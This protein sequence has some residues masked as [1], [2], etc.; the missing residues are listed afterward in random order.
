MKD[1]E[2]E[3]GINVLGVVPDKGEKNRSDMALAVSS[4]KDHILTEV[5]AGIRA[6]LT[7]GLY[8]DSSKSILVTSAGV[9]CGKTII[10]WS[11]QTETNKKATK[12]DIK[13]Q[14]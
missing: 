1:L 2:V 14:R 5:F 12:T 13:N 10:S 8:A 6:A 3:L 9:G 11:K 4:K 7:G